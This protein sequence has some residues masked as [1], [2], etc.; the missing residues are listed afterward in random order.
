VEIIAHELTH[1]LLEH[2]G[3]HYSGQ[4][5]SLMESFADV[6]G[7]LVKQ[8][9]LGQRADEAD[10]LMANGIVDPHE[11]RM[12]LR[13]LK[14]PGTAFDDERLGRDPQVARM[15]DY[16]RTEDDNGGVHINSGIPSHAFYLLSVTLGGRA[17]ERAG[18]IWYRALTG[19][20]L[21]PSADFATFAG[22]TVDEAGVDE[23]DAV[24]NAWKAVGVTPS[25][26][27][28]APTTPG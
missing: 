1:I 2:A 17:W 22:V 6:I 7:S 28:E 15:A 5:G 24:R 19:D 18:P 23:A 13:S 20:A 4:T 9:A 25:V 26:T 16:V 8:Y 10:W 11:S 14:A 3:L 12:P 27:G 21:P